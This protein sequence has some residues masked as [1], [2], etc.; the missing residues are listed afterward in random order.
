VL[1]TR[2]KKFFFFSFH[3]VG[4]F[5]FSLFFYSLNIAQIITDRMNK[6]KKKAQIITDQ[7]NKINNKASI[8]FTFI[9]I[10]DI[11]R[12]ISIHHRQQRRKKSSHLQ[13]LQHSSQ[14]TKKRRK[15]NMLSVGRRL[16]TGAGRGLSRPASA[17]PEAAAVAL[18]PAG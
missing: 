6:I 7:M 14:R 1:P 13:H 10:Y 12:T 18:P 5:S 2:T 15:K 17:A 9:H 11:F 16:P 3:P 4:L 8:F